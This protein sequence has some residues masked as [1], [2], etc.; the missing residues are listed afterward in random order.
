[1][2]YSIVAIHGLDGDRE[3][4]WKANNGKLWLKDP[5][6]LP[7]QIKNARILT[8]G[9]DAATWGTQPRAKVT[10]HDHAENFLQALVN[11][12]EFTHT[13]ALMLANQAHEGHLFKYRSFAEKTEGILFLGTPHQGTNG[14]T[15]AQHLADI[16]SI[17]TR[18]NNSLRKDL[19][20]YSEMLQDQVAAY[21][22]ISGQ[23]TTKFFY[24]VY[25]THLPDGSTPVI[26]PKHS[27]VVPGMVDAEAVGLN[28]DHSGM[29]KFDS[30]DDG[31]Y[32][33]VSTTIE[34]MVRSIAEEWVIQVTMTTQ[35]SPASTRAPLGGPPP[36]HSPQTVV[37]EDRTLSASDKN[38]VLK[39]HPL[40]SRYIPAM[41]TYPR[42]FG[43][44]VL[45]CPDSPA[46]DV[47]FIH[48]LDGHRI[49]S[50]IAKNKKMWLNDFLPNEM[51]NARIMTY[52]YDGYTQA[53][54]QFSNQTLSGHARDLLTKL[55][56]RRTGNETRPIIFIAHNVG[57]IILKSALI[58]ARACGD[59]HLAHHRKVF[60]ATTGI[61]FLGTPHQGT[62]N[63]YLRAVLNNAKKNDIVTRHLHEHSEWLQRQ[64][65]QYQSI[66]A[67]GR[68]TT[69]YVYE[70]YGTVTAPGME[71]ITVRD[72]LRCIDPIVL[73]AHGRRL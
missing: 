21:T 69:T 6:M 26:V 41:S 7:A 72:N 33:T 56:S 55:A 28:K 12:R 50:C 15:V 16:C 66:S 44:K 4:S 58:S 68:I 34:L 19:V 31:D 71:P 14:V 65:T 17:S 45:A 36:Y 49:E 24:E 22:A 8:Y 73:L 37:S 48:G 2:L 64:L 27:A 57:G 47:V 62:L 3:S 29:I 67:T 61:I 5:D 35:W 10:I 11:Y 30:P 18:F 60:D 40:R 46:F 59:H 25:G 1:P 53:R 20:K 52:G 70:N 38:V 23:Y 13:S 54:D 32:W 42:E 51:P 43:F 39:I 63:T 9:Y